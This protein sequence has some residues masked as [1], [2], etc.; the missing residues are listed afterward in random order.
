MSILTPDFRVQPNMMVGAEFVGSKTFYL[1]GSP[2]RCIELVT[3]IMERRARIHPKTV[4][5]IC[6]MRRPIFV[7]RP[8]PRSCT[9]S[10]I[11]NF[12][13]ALKHVDVISPNLVGLLTL[14]EPY[15]QSPEPWI[16][17]KDT[18]NRLLALGFGNKPSAVAVR[19]GEKGCYIATLQRHSWMPAY[20]ESPDQLDQVTGEER[21][22]SQRSTRP[23]KVVDP[24][25]AGHAFLGGFCVGLLTDPHP[26]GLTEFEV[27]GIY[28]SVAA[29]FAIE[30]VGMPKVSYH[31]QTSKEESWNDE[32]VRDRLTN[33]ERR[34]SYIPRLSERELRRASLYETRPSFARCFTNAGWPEYYRTR[35]LEYGGT[36]S[37]EGNQILGLGSFGV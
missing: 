27:A 24:T 9:P 25:G 1:T 29:S 16:W 8:S 22:Q 12:Y 11:S 34:L 33:F 4:A 36:A 14:C 6:G 5:G 2:A 17:M 13:E 7:W 10:E 3:A 37:E 35:K 15:L 20:H 32:A 21:T 28:G 18:C 19:I 30:Q 31:S 26:R 23:H